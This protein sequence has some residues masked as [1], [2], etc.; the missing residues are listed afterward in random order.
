MLTAIAV[1]NYRSLRNLIVPLQ[2]LNIVTGL[3]GSGKSSL[4]RSLRFLAETTKGSLIA[5]IAQEGGMQSTLWA[6]PEAISRAMREGRQKIE[7]SVRQDAVSLKFGFASDDYGYAIDMG[8][9]IPLGTSFLNDPQ[10]KRECIWAGQSCRPGNVLVDRRG[11]S[12]R[13][14][15]ERGGWQDIAVNLSTFESMMTA[16]SNPATAPEMLHVREMIQSWRFYDH[17]RIDGDSAIR[18]PQIGTY[19]PVLHGDG[20]NLAAALQTIVD[21][22][23]VTA[24]ND[25]IEDAFPGAGLNIGQEAGRFTVALSQSGLL[26]PLHAAELSDGTLRYLLLCAALL[27]PRPP[28]LM[29]LNE[30]E[31]S[32]HPDLVP[33]LGRLIGVASAKSQMIVVTH[34]QALISAL[35]KHSDAHSIH[36]EKN[37]GETSVAGLSALNRPSWDWPAR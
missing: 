34:S 28:Q 5:S 22:G 19:T 10:I 32:L 8:L 35:A 16:Y 17:F 23:D 15:G 6:G 37:F 7:G 2:K 27:S 12:M 33:A 20:V 36:L 24:L 14:R 3:N 9:P 21:I 13:V 25:A 29:V 26:R 4:Y 18:R 1:A 11:P 31:T 30:P